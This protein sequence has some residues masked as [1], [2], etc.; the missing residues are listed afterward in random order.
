MP[1]GLALANKGFTA[2]MDDPHLR[3]G[4]NVHRGRMTYEAVAESL[5]LPFSSES[6][7]R[8]CPDSWAQPKYSS[9]RGTAREFWYCHSIGKG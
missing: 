2:V 5:G 9:K 4:L 1:F 6:R 8:A 7:L 3:A